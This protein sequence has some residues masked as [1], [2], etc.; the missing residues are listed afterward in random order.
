MSVKAPA[1]R[2]FRRPRRAPSRGARVRARL[3]GRLARRVLVL[4]LL[5]AGIHQAITF[6]LTTPLLRVTTIAVRGNVRLSS[7][8]VQALVQDLRGAS[9]LGAD[10]DA[11]QRRLEASPWIA[12]VAMRRVLPSTIEVFVSERRPIGL[13]R[14]GDELHLVDEEGVVIDR[15][16]PRYAEFDLPIVD[17]LVPA[18][19]GKR[20][21]KAQGSID[22]ERAALAARVIGALVRNPAVAERLSLVDV[23]NVRDAVVLLE[24]DPALLHLGTERFLERVQAY[25]DL[26]GALRARVSDIDYVD[27]RFEHRVYVRPA[28]DRRRGADN[29]PGR[30]PATRRF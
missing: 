14:L 25:V 1:E 26:A 5:A 12:E 23:S 10:L 18:A 22:P 15:F 11:Y 7:S 16:G 4:V 30:L 17:G 3:S 20:Q 29:R 19:N 8:Q 21:G 27:L 24:D 6:V 9:I 13:C 28:D 2:N